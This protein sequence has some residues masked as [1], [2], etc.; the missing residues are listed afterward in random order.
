MSAEIDHTAPGRSLLPRWF[1]VKEVAVMLGFGETTVRMLILSG[2]LRSLKDGR[3]RRVLPE[4]ADEY[5]A[6]RVAESEEGLGE[7]A[8]CG[9]RRQHLPVRTRVPRL[10]CTATSPLWCGGPSTRG[11]TDGVERRGRE[12]LLGVLARRGRSGIPGMC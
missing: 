8:E 12:A 2:D 4:W 1:T 10:S 5:V 6:R 7:R 9:R 11:A 3:S